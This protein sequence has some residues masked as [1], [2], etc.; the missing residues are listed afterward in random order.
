MAAP[1]QVKLTWAGSPNYYSLAF[2]FYS[3]AGH[4]PAY[5]VRKTFDGNLQTVRLRRLVGW[6]RENNAKKKSA[7]TGT[8]MKDKIPFRQHSVRRKSEIRGCRSSLSLTHV[9]CPGSFKPIRAAVFWGREHWL[10]KMNSA[11][12][13]GWQLQEWGN[14]PPP[15]IAITGGE[16]IP[17]D[18]PLI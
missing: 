7:L 16:N 11:D 12:K 1:P 8:D 17:E 5:I 14:T 15:Y 18:T 4:I 13:V 6:T 2:L 3:G 9:Y 10:H